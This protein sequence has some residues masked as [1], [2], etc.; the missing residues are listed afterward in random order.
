MK[1]KT[2]DIGEM[3]EK[4]NSTKETHQKVHLWTLGLMAAGLIDKTTNKS[5]SKVCFK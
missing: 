4:Y 3:L 5:R 1:N 2:K